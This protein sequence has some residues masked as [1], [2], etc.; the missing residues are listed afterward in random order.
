MDQHLRELERKARS[1]DADAA[2]RLVTHRYRTATEKMEY[3]E[4]RDPIPGTSYFQLKESLAMAGE[5]LMQSF[6]IRLNEAFVGSP[7]NPIGIAATDSPTNNYSPPYWW[8]SL[9]ERYGLTQE[10]HSTGSPRIPDG[11]YGKVPGF[12]QMFGLHIEYT[13]HPDARRTALVMDTIKTNATYTWLGRPY[14]HMHVPMSQRG[15]NSQE[16]FYQREKELRKLV[17][18]AIKFADPEIEVRFSTGQGF[19]KGALP[20]T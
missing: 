6:L 15:W 10:L 12:Q 3:D 19:E 20:P 13:L 17:T 4:N 8:A 2:L 16:D 1:G 14:C 11:E 18:Q 9:K 5:L 7:F